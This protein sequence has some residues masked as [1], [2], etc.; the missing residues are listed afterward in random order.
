[1]MKKLWDEKYQFKKKKGRMGEMEKDSL[2]LQSKQKATITTKQS[3]F[4]FSHTSSCH[5]NLSTL[6]LL[7]HRGRLGVVS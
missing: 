4:P 1:M 3:I 7:P 2:L 6:S 5:T